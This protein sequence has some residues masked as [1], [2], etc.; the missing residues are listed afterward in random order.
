MPF[1]HSPKHLKRRQAGVALIM[2]LVFLVLLTILGL[3]AMS[4]TILQEK[5]TANMKDKNLAFQA[6]ET[7]LVTAEQW[8]NAQLSKPVFPNTAVGL[9]LPSTTDTA[10]WDSVI[11]SGTVN[12]VVF[13]NTPTGSGVGSLASVET[14]PK[15]IIEDLGEAQDGSLVLPKD[16]KGVGKTI[17]RITARGTGGTDS[18]QAMVQSTF[19]RQF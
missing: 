3:T 9:Y 5:M 17:L 10:N 16:Y 19:G 1:L 4:T 6:A 13:P 2:S 7:G 15:Y 8:L 12:L 14:A 18:A 11:W